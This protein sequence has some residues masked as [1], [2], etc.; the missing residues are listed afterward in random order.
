MQSKFASFGMLGKHHTE[1][2][3]RKMRKKAMVVIN[4]LVRNVI[5][6]LKQRIPIALNVGVNCIGYKKEKNEEK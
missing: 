5:R 4:I 6:G 3:K 2:T 1:A